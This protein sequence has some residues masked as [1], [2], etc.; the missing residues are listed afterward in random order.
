MEKENYVPNDHS[1]NAV[2][3]ALRNLSVTEGIDTSNL[4]GEQAEL[5]AGRYERRNGVPET[6]KDVNMG[7]IVFACKSFLQGYGARGE[8]TSDIASTVERL[9]SQRNIPPYGSIAKDI[10]LP[11]DIMIGPSR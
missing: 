7:D 3:R 4:R 10:V 2:R 5:L 1:V 11:V 8:E 9:L 6:A